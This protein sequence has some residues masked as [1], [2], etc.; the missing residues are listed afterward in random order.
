MKYFKVR[1]RSKKGSTQ[2]IYP[3]G[4]QDDVGPFAKDHLYYED[5]GHQ[6]LLLA[7]PDADAKK[8]VRKDIVEIKKAEAGAIS[9]AKEP[10]TET[11]TDEAKVRRL[12][13]KAQLKQKFAPSELKALDPNDPTP[14]FSKSVI[15][16]DRM[17]KLNEWEK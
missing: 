8:I 7:I 4:Y 17:A 12:Q 6:M 2:M 13:I 5:E 3:K 10:R 14:G 1:V 16:A 11:I 9:E 15:F